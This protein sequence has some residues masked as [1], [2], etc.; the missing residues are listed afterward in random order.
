ML[1]RSLLKRPNQAWQEL[2]TFFARF[3]FDAEAY[4]LTR[5]AARWI[6]PLT[7]M[8]LY[9]QQYKNIPGLEALISV[10]WEKNGNLDQ[11]RIWLKKARAR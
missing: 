4:K 10:I 5:E 7:L 11:A 3:S 9:H 8:K 2:T 1:F 6:A